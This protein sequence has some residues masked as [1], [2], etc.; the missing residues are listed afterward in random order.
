M[1]S[2]ELTI[3]ALV[4]L[5]LVALLVTIVLVTQKR[6]RQRSVLLREKFGPEYERALAQHGDQARAE[7]E[8]LSRQKRLDALDIHPL[9]DAQA[10]QFGSAW[11]TV[12][13][14]FV[15]DPASAVSEA[16]R[17]IKEVMNARGYPLGNFDQRVADLSVEHANVVS[18]YRSARELARAREEGQAGTE[19]LRQAMVHY[20][21]LFSDMLR[22]PPSTPPLLQGARA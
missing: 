22:T 11:A 9:S 21:A 2:N 5:A 20:R 10:D 6:N 4:T 12:Q 19:E 1:N 15:D 14:R 18:H 8:L 17:L 3:L 13:Q 7:R 16:D